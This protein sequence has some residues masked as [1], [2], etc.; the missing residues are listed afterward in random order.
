VEVQRQ[1]DGVLFLTDSATVFGPGGTESVAVTAAVADAASN[2]PGFTVMELVSPVDGVESVGAVSL[3]TPIE[4]GADA[5][6]D[7]DLRARVLQRIRNI[8]QGGAEADYVAW[9][10]AVADVNRAWVYPE[11]LG[12]GTVVVRF[13]VTDSAG[14]PIPDAGQV[15]AVQEAIDERRPVTAAVT[16]VAP[17][18]QAIDLTIAVEPDTAAVRAAVEAELAALFADE[19][20]PGGT[21]KNSVLRATLSQ[22]EGET[23]HVLSNVDGDASG[24]SDV[25]VGANAIPVLGTVTWV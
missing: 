5:E 24:L 12:P 9:A 1:A 2:S 13:T 3:V 6:T 23:S 7:P 25:V 8:P 15:T 18:A 4:G 17:V 16:V 11:Q 20:E 10:L 21:I 14:G 22:A 19:G